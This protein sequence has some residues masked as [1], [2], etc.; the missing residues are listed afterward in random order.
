[1]HG[2]IESVKHDLQEKV[3]PLERAQMGM[4]QWQ[5]QVEA[6]MAKIEANLTEM[7]ERQR[8]ND[9][10]SEAVYQAC[11]SAV[12]KVDPTT[13]IALKTLAG[14]VDELDSIAHGAAQ[15]SESSQK[16]VQALERELS[17]LQ[18]KHEQVLSQLEALQQT[19]QF[20]GGLRS[21]FQWDWP[22]WL[23]QGHN[24]FRYRRPSLM[25][26]W[27]QRRPQASQR[28]LREWKRERRLSFLLS[29]H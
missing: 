15:A 29:R 28:N 16:D 11:T 20:E 22:E 4:L 26:R 17:E 21:E 7:H 8:R 10:R 14:R 3:I 19:S 23:Q 24:S 9:E 18:I 13:Q 27:M 12:G 2:Q 25:Q 6:H 5:A 1:M